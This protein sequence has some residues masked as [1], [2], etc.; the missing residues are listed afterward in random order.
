M[1]ENKKKIIVYADWKD[2]FNSLTDEEAGRLIKHFFSYVNDE[3]PTSDRLTELLFIPIKTT[4]KRDLKSWEDYVNKQRE[5]GGKGGRPKKEETQETQAFINKPK[6]GDSDNDSV[7]VNDNVSE[8]VKKEKTHAKNFHEMSENELVEIFS[9][10][11][12]DNKSLDINELSYYLLYSE[13]Y[14]M[15]FKSAYPQ[16]D[17]KSYIEKF[18][19]YS[20]SGGKLHDSFEN[21]AQHFFNTIRAKKI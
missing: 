10:P 4:L 21:Y 2:Q 6:K 18:Y 9:N 14:G 17:Y 7:S 8:S 16:L 19:T 1:A 5:N 13:Q 11:P 3:N 20:L 12:T 15:A